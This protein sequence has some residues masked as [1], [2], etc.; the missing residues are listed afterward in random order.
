LSEFTQN[1]GRSQ[2]GDAKLCPRCK[3]SSINW[4]SRRRGIYL[5]VP[6]TA[7]DFQKRQNSRESRSR[8]GRR[9]RSGRSHANL[10]GK[11]RPRTVGGKTDYFRV[12][13]QLIVGN[14][15]SLIGWP[16]EVGFQNMLWP[17]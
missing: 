2:R 3:E 10:G 9:R 14:R 11:T 1:S 7:S 8:R 4:W 5:G 13:E 16:S 15:S 17:P 6:A 12:L